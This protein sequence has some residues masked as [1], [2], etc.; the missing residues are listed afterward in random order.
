VVPFIKPNNWRDNGY[1]NAWNAYRQMN[2]LEL[3]NNIDFNIDPVFGHALENRQRIV[4]NK[5]EGIVVETAEVKKGD[6]PLIKMVAVMDYGHWNFMP[7]ARIMWDFFSH[8]SRN[9]ED[10]SLIYTK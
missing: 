8:Y 3:V 9:Q 2:G 5:G 1:L 6:M 10:Y 4:T 7:T